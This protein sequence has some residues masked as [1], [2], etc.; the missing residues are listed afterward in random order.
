MTGFSPANDTGV[1]PELRVMVET[2]RAAH[3][4]ALRSLREAR[5][6]ALDRISNVVPEPWTRAR[7]Q[8]TVAME[9][10][11][12]LEGAERAKRYGSLVCDFIAQGVLQAPKLVVLSTL[13]GLAALFAQVPA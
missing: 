5:D 6:D 11:S 12:E 7:L 1:S 8:V 10:L 13:C 3:D 4:T 2:R 9:K